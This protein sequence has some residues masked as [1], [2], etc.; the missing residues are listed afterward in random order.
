VQHLDHVTTREE[1][2]PMSEKNIPN[3]ETKTTGGE[4]DPGKTRPETAKDIGKTAVRGT[5]GK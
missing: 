4:G 1:R 5:R 3:P 2:D